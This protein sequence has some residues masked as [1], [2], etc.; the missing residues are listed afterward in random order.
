MNFVETSDAFSIKLVR[1]LQVFWTEVRSHVLSSTKITAIMID[2]TQLSGSSP[3]QQPA[4]RP[5]PPSA[6]A[7]QTLQ[8]VCSL[9]WAAAQLADP[10]R[11]QSGPAASQLSLKGTRKHYLVCVRQYFWSGESWLWNIGTSDAWNCG[12]IYQCV[13]I[14]IMLHFSAWLRDFIFPRR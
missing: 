3:S 7:L 14:F 2:S 4:S 13:P 9:Q 1:D 11:L 5:G 12:K 10:S 8:T 6:P